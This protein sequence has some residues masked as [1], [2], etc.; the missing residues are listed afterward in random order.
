[1]RRFKFVILSSIL[2]TSFSAVAQDDL[3]SLR[4]RLAE[5]EAEQAETQGSI[6]AL[7]AQIKALATETEDDPQTEPPAD[8]PQSDVIDV[9]KD[10][11]RR[12]HAVF[13]EI[14]DESR[15]MLL[16]KD[17]FEFGID[18]L[19]AARYEYSHREDDGTGSS[20]N[21]HGFQN[22]ATRVNLRGTLFKKFGLSGYPSFLVLK[23]KL[24]SDPVMV[25]PFLKGRALTVKEFLDK[26]RKGI[27]LGY[28]K[29]GTQG[30]KNK[31]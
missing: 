12:R 28:N 26:I 15:F 18:G 7:R 14:A 20:S 23:P 30:N 22:T 4:R 3:D 6:E 11:V 31:R 8:D 13:P 29:R 27:A 1:M 25:S 21:Q 16:S 2:L 24:R 17:G 10:S 5:V 19:V 9:P